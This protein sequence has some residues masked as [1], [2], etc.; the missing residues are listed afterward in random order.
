LL[1]ETGVDVA[2]QLRHL[3]GLDQ[4][5]GDVGLDDT[6]CELDQDGVVLF[7]GHGRLPGIEGME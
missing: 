5:L 6:G 4:V 7:F 2:E 3:I 1:I